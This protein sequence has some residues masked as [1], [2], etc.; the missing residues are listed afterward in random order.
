M[1]IHRSLGVGQQM[2]E[3]VVGSAKLGA[4]FGTFLGG[5]LAQGLGRAVHARLGSSMVAAAHP[6][7]RQLE[8]ASL[9]ASQSRPGPSMS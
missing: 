9:L 5:G 6:R 8:S 4:V 1:A 2:Q 7:R 3:L